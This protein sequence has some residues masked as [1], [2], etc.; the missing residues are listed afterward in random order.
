[1]KKILSAWIEQFIEFSSEME[2]VAFH[3]DLKNGRKAYE[4]MSEEKHSDGSM[5]IH[6]R[7]QYNNNKFPERG[8][9]L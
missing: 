8:D 9:A 7:R 4:V 5:L 1:M 6:L 2:W 3:H